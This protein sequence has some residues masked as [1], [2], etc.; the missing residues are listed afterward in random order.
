MP[1]RVNLLCGQHQIAITASAS[2]SVADWVAKG[3]YW[4]IWQCT[5]IPKPARQESP[6]SFAAWFLCQ[7]TKIHAYIELSVA[8]PVYLHQSAASIACRHPLLYHNLHTVSRHAEADPPASDAGICLSISA[9]VE[10][11][12]LRIMD[13]FTSEPLETAAA[14]RQSGRQAHKPF[15]PANPAASRSKQAQSPGISSPQAAEPPPQR[16]KSG[17]RKKSKGGKC[18]AQAAQ[19]KSSVQE[20]DAGIQRAS[21]VHSSGTLGP[22]KLPLH[23]N[24]RKNAPQ[25]SCINDDAEGPLAPS[26]ASANDDQTSQAHTLPEL[27][28][29]QVPHPQPS[30]RSSKPS[31]A[32]HDA[33]P[34]SLSPA[35]PLLNELDNSEAHSQALP[36][37]LLEL[38]GASLQGGDRTHD[39]AVPPDKLWTF[40]GHKRRGA[41]EKSPSKALP[42]QQTGKQLLAGTSIG[43]DVANGECTGIQMRQALS[44]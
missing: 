5:C 25:T 36:S 2:A 30:N 20:P 14:Q 12:V 23:E 6:W 19:S 28:G 9:C 8:K 1:L 22:P 39:Q 41:K 37:K 18:N 43:D 11:A 42:A 16:P 27:S 44:L 31:A 35:A 34:A 29:A 13:L 3:T 17:S 32:P 10:A 38:Q 26:A 7:L 33:E 21:S 24:S 15:K 4:E 40:K